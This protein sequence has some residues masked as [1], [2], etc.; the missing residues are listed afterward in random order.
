MNKDIKELYKKFCAIKEQG[1]IKSERKGYTGVGYTFEK[2]I[3]K[4]EENFPIPDFKS[5]EIKTHRKY[6]KRNIHLFNAT[7]DGDYLFPI[8][9]I[10]E[11]LGYPD[12]N[13][14]KIKIFNMSFT[15]K[16]FTNI[17]YYKKGKIVVDEEN[18]KIKFIVYDYEGKDLNMNVSW[19]YK[20]LKERLDLKLKYL[21][22]I[23]ADSKI[24]NNNEYFNYNE[25]NFY[26]LKDFN[27]FIE[28]IKTGNIVV[29]FKIGV[30]KD[31]KRK[32]QI[33]DRGTDFSISTTDFEKLYKKIPLE[34][35]L[36]LMV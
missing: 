3:Q 12:K 19:S 30:F 2:L 36:Y 24:K 22:L 23:N 18:E 17:G 15:A 1:W 31:G 11:T 6:S 21:A 34:Y 14:K 16:E 32:G 5:I 27:S 29:N 7:P 20:L 28:L 26:K 25:I 9:R 8:K 13:D 10:L 35:F 4:E 33:H